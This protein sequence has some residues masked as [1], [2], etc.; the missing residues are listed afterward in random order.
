MSSR[1]R[2]PRDMRTQQPIGH[3]LE[4]QQAPYMG[5]GRRPIGVA[6]PDDGPKDARSFLSRS[7]RRM[8]ED[9]PPPPPEQLAAAQAQEP[10]A[11]PEEEWIE[12]TNSQVEDVYYERPPQRQR[13]ENNPNDKYFVVMAGESGEA[14][15][16]EF[17]E[18]ELQEFLKVAGPDRALLGLHGELRPVLW[19]GSFLIIRGN[20][21]KPEM[22]MTFA[23]KPL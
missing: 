17:T 11:I 21:V 6:V 2:G 15:V 20:I 22:Q 1:T 8:E 12:A 19:G 10:V 16:K 9:I 3:P 18:S 13:R 14:E 4:Q 7:P 23:L 5:R